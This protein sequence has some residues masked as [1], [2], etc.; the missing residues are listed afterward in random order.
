M[1]A[2]FGN[3]VLQLEIAN[4]PENQVRGLAG[5][6][7]LLPNWGML[8]VFPQ[9]VVLPFTMRGMYFPIDIVF[10]DVSH[11]VVGAYVNA[12]PGTEVIPPPGP[13]R[14]V[15]ETPAGYYALRRV[16]AVLW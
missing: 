8:F 9:D 6:P 11:R 5:R 4:T 12:K 10:L 15:I 16:G 14:Y 3:E 7:Y 13:Y 2:R 1:I